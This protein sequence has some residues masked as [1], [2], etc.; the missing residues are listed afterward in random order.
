MPVETVLDLAAMTARV[1]I[2]ADAAYCSERYFMRALID[3]T[4][5]FAEAIRLRALLLL[6]AV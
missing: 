1:V 6:Q 5:L 4:R 3:A 2:C